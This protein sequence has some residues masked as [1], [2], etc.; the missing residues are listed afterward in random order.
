MSDD[1]DHAGTR[2]ENRG[3]GRVP[4][5][6]HDIS[7]ADQSGDADPD[8]VDDHLTESSRRQVEEGVTRL[9]RPFGALLLTGVLGA[10]EIG[11]GL[12]AMWTVKDATGSD[13]LGAM[14]FSIGLVIILM[15][16]SELFTEGFLV[17][18][19]A[20][21]RK[22]ATIGRLLRFWAGTLLGN[23]VGAAI[24]MWILVQAYPAMHPYLAEQGAKYAHMAPTLQHV[25]LAALGGMALT[26]VTR[27]HQFTEEATPKIIASAIGGF[28]LAGTGV[29][30]CILDTLYI[31]GAIFSGA[32]G[33]TV[34][35]WAGF[36]WWSA[37]A[38]MAGGLLLVSAIRFLRS[39]GVVDEREDAA[40]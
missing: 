14:A 5:G 18:V 13:V 22:R 9:A 10:M 16:H 35:D 15:A 31:Y 2:D 38:N 17:P 40:G 30:H 7:P 33:V 24:I 29:V 21:A 27:M 28:V 11:L 4:D 6:D 32:D 3:D 37:L 25:L 19:A 1:R 12:L 26:V 36:I 39:R 8:H 23:L 34:G 20:V